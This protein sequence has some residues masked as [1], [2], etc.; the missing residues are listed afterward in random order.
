MSET[1]NNENETAHQVTDEPVPA[2][3]STP[4]QTTSPD[5][6]VSNDEDEPVDDASVPETDGTVTP[7]EDASDDANSSNDV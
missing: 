2:N 6:V 4:Q 3:L 7:L 1:T 5:V